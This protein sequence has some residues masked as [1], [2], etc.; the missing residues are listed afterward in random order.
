MPSLLSNR[1][2]IVNG[3]KISLQG[4]YVQIGELKQPFLLERIFL[5]YVWT[6]DT[7]PYALYTEQELR[8]LRLIHRDFTIPPYRHITHL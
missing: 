1:E 2:L 6:V 5:I 3:L 8:L 7:I 4:Q